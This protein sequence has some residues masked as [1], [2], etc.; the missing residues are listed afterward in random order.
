MNIGIDIRP[1]MEESRT[2]VGEYTC[3]L[4]NALF[5]IDKENQYFLFY[6]S[7]KDV[8]KNIPKW[9]QK[10]VHYIK[11]RYPNKLFNFFILFFKFPKLDKLIIKNKQSIINNLDYFFSPNINFLALSKKTKLI[12]TIHDISFEFFPDCFSLKRRLWHKILDP[13]KQCKKADIILVPSENTKQD[14]INFYDVPENKIKVLYPGLSKKFRTLSAQAVNNTESIKVVRSK[15]NLPDKFIL[16]LGTL[17]PRKNIIG[18]IQAFKFSKLFPP[19]ADPSF[20]RGYELV[21][22]G[23]KG[24]KIEPIMDLI[25][26]TKGVKYIGYVDAKDKPMLY[27]LASIFVYPS[28]YEGFGFPVIEAMASHTPV[29]TSNRSSI[30]EISDNAA[31]LV[32]PNNVDEI[33]RGMEVLSKDEKLCNLLIENGKKRIEKF[34]WSSSAKEFVN[35]INL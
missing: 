10:N 21:I 26:V 1:L 17:E 32:N 29:V 4:L 19:E 22:A 34:D 2:G 30:P 24:W 25:N 3:E 9:R 20:S 7:G 23:T 27:S 8:S 35:L 15:Y 5:D 11:S 18:I 28:L 16:F 6:N 13:K 33:R 12:L 14:I 31:Y